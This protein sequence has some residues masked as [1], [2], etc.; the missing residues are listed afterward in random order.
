[1]LNYTIEERMELYEAFYGQRIQPSY[2]KTIKKSFWR[3]VETITKDVAYYHKD[4]SPEKMKKA[5]LIALQ[6]LHR[7][8]AKTPSAYNK[9]PDMGLRAFKHADRY[10][11][12]KPL[13]LPPIVDEEEAVDAA[14]Q[15]IK[16][17]HQKLRE[18][19][20]AKHLSLI[21]ISEPTR[22]Y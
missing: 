2:A 7:L 8:G 20:P 1:M 12:G 6:V 15:Q 10:L 4:V 11:Q 21:H 22:P 5:V 18:E 3:M 19:S 17:L 13:K 9:V 16:V 14:K